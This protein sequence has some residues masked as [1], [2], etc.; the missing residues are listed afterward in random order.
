MLLSSC[1]PEPR[2]EI[3]IG[4]IGPLSGNAVDLGLAP[5]K[6]IALAIQ[7][8][9]E[10]RADDDPIVT[11]AFEDDGW[12][13]ANAVTLYDKLRR[14][15]GI[16]I[17]LISHTD[18]TIALQEKVKA[19][20]VLLVNSLN[21]DQLLSTMN[22]N[23]FVI[24]KKTEET[25][26]VVASRVVELGKKRVRGF[27]VTNS[28]M[29]ISSDAFSELLQ[30]RGVEVEILPVDISKV[31]FMESLEEFKEDGCDALAFFGYKNLG[32]AMKQARELGMEVPFFASTTTLGEGYYENSE[33]AL[34]GTEFSFFTPNDGNYILAR[35]FLDRYRLN[36]GEEPFSVWPPMQA[37]DAT[38]MILSILQNGEQRKGETLVSWLKRS[39]HEINYFQRSLRKYRCDERWHIARHLFLSLHGQ[40]SGGYPEGKA[41]VAYE[42]SLQALSRLQPNALHCC[43]HRLVQPS[44]CVRSEGEFRHLRE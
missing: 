2:E 36:Y 33:G 21:N 41:V 27:Y 18:G 12:D 31:D 14:E 8:Y 9:N 40:G 32:Y 3:N 6:A 11:F 15:H 26:Q 30:R 43:I 35:Q 19:D 29:T 37:Y 7:E 28:F 13:G 22:E 25:A 34:K 4:F 24:G 42:N 10:T 20:G 17:L 38:S 16:D 1:S 44:R 23:T 39:L 5:S